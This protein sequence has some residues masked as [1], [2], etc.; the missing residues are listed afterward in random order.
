MSD[1]W[2]A[3]AVFVCTIIGVGIF[4]LPWVGYKAGF[5]LLAFYFLIL[6]TVAIVIHLLFGQVCLGTKTIHRFPGYVEKYLGQTWGKIALADICLGLFGAQLAYLLVGGGFLSDLISPYLGGNHFVYTFLFFLIGSY[7]IFRGIKSISLAEFLI[8]VFF[9]I[10][11]GILFV[12]TF[13]QISIPNLTKIN[14]RFFSYPYGVVLFSLWGSAIVPEIKEMVK[15]KRGVFRKVIIAGIIT[16]ALTYLFFVVIVL[17]VSGSGTTKDAFSGLAPAL[18]NGIIKVGY[19]FGVITC[20]SSFLTLGLTLKKIFRYDLK[21]SENKSWAIA[22]FVPFIFYLS[23]LREY[24]SVIS[25]SGAVA[26]GIEGLID[27]FLYRAFVKKKY[28]RKI[29]PLYYLLPLFFILGVVVEIF[30][31]LAK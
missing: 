22:C 7:L 16:T 14:L 13:S 9:F 30:Y 20:F 31:F 29:N 18:G 23:G 26:I 11:L 24:I 10:I 2:K 4:G 12:K 5:L 28:S 17:G 8:S 1:F 21:L 6:S 27:V 3:L 15:G 19:V 25:L